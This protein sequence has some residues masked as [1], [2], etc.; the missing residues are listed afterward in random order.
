M[1]HLDEAQAA[2]MAITDELTRRIRAEGYPHARFEI[3]I[4]RGQAGRQVL[5]YVDKPPPNFRWISEA[6][7]IAEVVARAQ[8]EIDRLPDAAAEHRALARWFE[9]VPA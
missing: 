4:G 1:N 6:T 9:M 8:D 3:W 7:T 5:A 2:I